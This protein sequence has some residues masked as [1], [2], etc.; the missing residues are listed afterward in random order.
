MSGY[1]FGNDE[2]IEE[3]ENLVLKNPTKKELEKLL[4]LKSIDCLTQLIQLVDI[5]KR[6]L[7]DLLCPNRLHAS[8]RNRIIL[9]EEFEKIEEAIDKMFN[10]FFR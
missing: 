1:C 7:T 10:C 5:L 3:S 8:T 4:A 6:N 2:K 9:K